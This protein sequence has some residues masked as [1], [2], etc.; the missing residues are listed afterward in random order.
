VH[1]LDR[2][3]GDE[4]R[5]SKIVFERRKQRPE[6]VVDAIAG[7]VAPG[8]CQHVVDDHARRAEMPDLAREVARQLA[9]VVAGA[10]A[11]LGEERRLAER[12]RE[13]MADRRP[14]AVGNDQHRR[15]AAPNAL[16]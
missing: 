5:A 13:A 1:A 3:G 6:E 8:E 11:T 4:H 7:D 10:A 15:L 2:A 14:C 12:D 16:H 9:R